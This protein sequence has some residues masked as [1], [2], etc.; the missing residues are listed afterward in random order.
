MEGLTAKGKPLKDHLDLRGHSNAIN[1]LLGFV[2][3]Q[4][5]LTEA[6][7]RKLHEILLIEPY[8]SQAITPDGLPTMKTIGLGCYKT[9]PNHVRTPTG[10]MHFYASPEETPAK[11]H[12]LM[13]WYRTEKDR[14]VMHPVEIAARYHHSFTA[15]HPFDDGNGRMSRLLMNLILMQAGYPPSVIRIG[16]RD[17]Y[18]AALRRADAG[19]DEDFLTFIGEHVAESLELFVRAARGEDIQEPTDL[20]KEIVLLKMELSQQR[21]PNVLD[22]FIQ[23]K[24]FIDSLDPLFLEAVR[25]LRPLCDLFSETTLTYEARRPSGNA[26]V[27][28]NQG[29]VSLA[30]LKMAPRPTGCWAGG[31][32]MSSLS[33]EFRLNGFKRGGFETFDLS[34]PLACTFE[35]LKFVVTLPRITPPITIQHFYQDPLTRAEIKDIAQKL[36][37]SFVEAIKQKTNGRA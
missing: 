17:Q 37:R 1:Y 5:V 25:L 30:D 28:F 15:I 2:R 12:D 7:I 29:S 9:Q 4:E 8:R 23:E 19:E 36:A 35:R 3:D 6:A 33:T 13:E 22:V 18:L 21:E 27:V 31:K 10:E 16:E 11:M 34:T 24:L 32:V 26:T 20:E 14:G